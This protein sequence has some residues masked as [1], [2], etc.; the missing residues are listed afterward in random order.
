MRHPISLFFSRPLLSIFVFGIASGFPWVMIGSVMSAWLQESGLT[1]SAIGYFGAVFVVY[2]VNFLWSP[3]IDRVRLPLLARAL[4]QRRSW[5]WLMQVCIVLGCLGLAG[6]DPSHSLQLAGLTALSIALASATQD[7]AIDAFRIDSIAEDHPEQQSAASAMATSG[8][9]TGYAGL[10]AIPFF[11]ADD[12]G[13]SNVYL[14]L[15]AIMVVI[16]LLGFIAHEPLSNRNAT[17]AAV[18]Q[19][20][21]DAVKG[22]HPR[23]LA[24][25][26]GVL[27]IIVAIMLNAFAA[28]LFAYQTQVTA[29]VVVAI[30]TMI[31]HSLNR[32]L[33]NSNQTV[34]SITQAEQVVAWILSTLVE[35]LRDFFKRNGVAMAL[36][37]LSF[38]LLFKLG[39]AFLGR[40]SIV[41]Y[42]EIGFSNEDIGAYSKLL[43]W[44][45][46]VVASVIG[47]AITLR[48]GLIKGLVIGGVSMAASNLLFSL[49]AITGPDKT[50]LGITIVI[51]GFTAAWGTVV[52]M[53]FISALCNRA[54]T[55]SQYALLASIGTLGRVSLGAYSG[56][57]VDALDGDWAIFFVITALMIIP[58]MWLLYLIRHRLKPLLGMD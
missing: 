49:M 20:Y 22:H 10:G 40:M 17:F 30:L 7:I 36:A 39:E 33:A 23:A 43:T 48:I 57:M 32:I 42:K 47:A 46:T 34:G 31:F 50:L 19:K 13:W 25:L 3:L 8:W 52:F 35:P 24:M 6:V 14:L 27:L 12:I 21:Q 15:A 1:R 4:G 29:V 2:S 56:V 44:L 55:A 53:S 51:D 58:S 18:Q 26:L 16:S 54:F 9:W 5:I 41:F 38:V 11:L 28:P 45:V 37:L